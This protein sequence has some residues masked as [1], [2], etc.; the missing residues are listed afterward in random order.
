MYTPEWLS[1]EGK[2]F[3]EMVHKIFREEFEPHIEEYEAQGIIPR[4]FW[5][6]LAEQGILCPSMPVE[7]GG[8]GTDFT[9]NM[10]VGFEC[11]YAIGGTNLGI[12]LQS[13]ILAY[14]LL[15]HGTEEQ[16]RHYLP[17][18]CS[19]ELIGG[20]AMTEP[21]AGSDVKAIRTTAARSG[22]QYEI[23][24]QKTFITNG[25]NA[26]FFVVACKTDTSKGANGISLLI[27]EADREGFARGRNLSKLGQ[28]AADTSELFFDRVCVP[29][30][31]L[32]GEENKGFFILMD[33]LPRERL[34]VA[35]KS[36]GAAQRSYELTRDYIR[37]RVVFGKKLEE[38]Q[39]TR[40][41]M[42]EM[43]T[44]LAAAWAL[45]DRCMDKMIRGTLDEV[46]GAM[47]KLFVSEA[48]GRIVDECLQLFGGW[49]YMTEYPISRFYAD[50]RVRRI[51]AGTSEIMKLVI[52]RKL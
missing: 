26:D 9:F 8:S 48:E 1:E 30:A 39:N 28:K 12:T 31:N 25:Q 20:L 40:F 52:S 41:K 46:D 38:F 15:N 47:V 13:D 3:Q 11:G 17:G 29:A 4:S 43:K 51:F 35:V 16:K 19:A 50:A 45:V 21:G 22:D 33:E 23:N 18:M 24:G 49:G 37:E 6:R 5:Y 14:Y 32:L 7:Y 34:A 27:V 2:I 42:A 44:Q 10:A 36:I